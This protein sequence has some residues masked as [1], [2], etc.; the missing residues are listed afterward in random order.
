MNRLHA[1]AMV[2]VFVCA[3]SLAWNRIPAR[4]WAAETIQVIKIAHQ[5]RSALIKVNNGALRVVHVGDSVA[6]YG[7]IEMIDKERIVFKN[8]K[9]E[10]NIIIVKNGKQAVEHIARIN[11]TARPLEMNIRNNQGVD[12]NIV[13]TDQGNPAKG[14]KVKK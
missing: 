2:V 12:G 8:K 6:P 13:Q 9:L 10:K 14:M 4:A 3:L 1:V 11:T 7:R 5:D